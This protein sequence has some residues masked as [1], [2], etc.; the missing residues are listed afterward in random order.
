MKGNFRSE[1]LRRLKKILKSKLTSK[2]TIS[3]INSRAVSM[4]RYSAGIVTWRVNELQDLDLKT[5]KLL[6]MYSRFHKKGDVE[7][8]CTLRK[9]KEA[10]ASL[11]RTVCMNIF[12]TARS[13]SLW[14]FKEKG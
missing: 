10:E 8:G 1:R 7:T 9:P 14:R 2:N 11:K 12:V 5:R 4:I 3:A 13:Q 6:T